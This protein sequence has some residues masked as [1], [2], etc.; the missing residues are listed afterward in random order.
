MTHPETDPTDPEPVLGCGA[1]SAGDVVAWCDDELAPAD[2]RRVASHCAACADCARAA[3]RLRRSAAALAALPRLQPSA[4]F[5]DRVVAAARAQGAV[6][7]RRRVVRFPRWAQA[8]AAAVVVAV[9]GTWF[10]LRPSG[11]ALSARDAEDIARDLDVLAHIE[12][13]SAADADELASLADDLDAI[14]A[15]REVLQDDGG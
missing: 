12:T 11:D 7:P 14:E 4:H 8:A 15:S 5:A 10:A 1:L 2:A 13:L 3:D 6:A 9:A